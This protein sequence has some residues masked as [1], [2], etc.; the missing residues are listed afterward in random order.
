MIPEP[1]DR[2]RLLHS[3]DWHL[4]RRLYGRSQREYCARFLDWLLEKMVEL[5]V[6]ALI[7]AGDI[8]DTAAPSP[9]VQALYYEFL[10]QVCRLPLRPEVVVIAGNHDSPSLLSAPGALLKS[11][12]IHVVGTVSPEG[13][14]ELICLK[15][16]SGQSRLVVCAVPH[17][18]DRDLR[19]SAAGEGPQ[20]KERQLVA[21]IGGHYGRLARK[22]A[23]LKEKLGLNLPVAATGHL[24][25]AGGQ[26]LEGDGVR[27]LYVGS[28]GQVPVDIFPPVFDYVALG[29]LHQAQTVGKNPSRRYC[30]SPLAM[31]F[32]E[33][34]QVKSITVADFGPQAGPPDLF[35][36]AVP[37]FQPLARL[38]GDRAQLCQ[39]LTKLRDDGRSLWLELEY[40]G[41]ELW[42]DLRESLAELVADSRLEIL[43]LRRT[44]PG[45]LGPCAPGEAVEELQNL[46]A[47]Q[48]F[49]RLLDDRQVPAEQRPPLLAAYDEILFQ[50]A[51][52]PEPEEGV[53]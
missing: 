29:H 6:Q 46:D 32:S 16:A 40:N 31:S 53:A 44:G 1:G 47:R 45:A 39:A 48:L 20:D 11:L 42:P 51:Q 22:A 37:E 18:R 52:E 19:L 36:L 41:S 25:A 21:A 14:D 38:S 17:P 35:A 8:F 50:L 24:F 3:S 26:T 43:R 5:K 9:A 27:P 10:A 7:V 34:G 49:E 15:D 4:G 12:H 13:E 30:G 33:A 23:E 28:L 2:F